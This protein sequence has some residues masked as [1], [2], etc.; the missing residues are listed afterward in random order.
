M[1]T[2]LIDGVYRPVDERVDAMIAVVMRV[3]FGRSRYAASHRDSTYL[4]R[5]V[6]K[7]NYA[8]LKSMD[9]GYQPVSR[10]EDPFV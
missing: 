9:M 7:L 1:E 5:D 6:T 2:K 3:H 10:E 8:S 4:F